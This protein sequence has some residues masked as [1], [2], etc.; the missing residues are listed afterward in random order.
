MPALVAVTM[1]IMMVIT[2]TRMRLVNDNDRE[3]HPRV[4]YERANARSEPMS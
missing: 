3:Q 1:T 4:I 2:K